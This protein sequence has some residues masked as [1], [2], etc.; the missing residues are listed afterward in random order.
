MSVALRFL[1]DVRLKQFLYVTTDCLDVMC[2]DASASDGNWS[3]VARVDAVLHQVCLSKTGEQV[4]ELLSDEFPEFFCSRLGDLIQASDSVQPGGRLLGK[5]ST[6]LLWPPLNVRLKVVR[7][8]VGPDL[9][10]QAAVQ[11]V[12]H[13]SLETVLEVGLLNDG[14]ELAGHLFQ[15]PNAGRV[16]LILDADAPHSFIHQTA[17]G[18]FRGVLLLQGDAVGVTWVDCRS[19]G[20]KL[21]CIIDVQFQ[22]RLFRSFP[23][24]EE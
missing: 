12:E 15:F 4:A 23:E 19:E 6:F 14:V 3:V 17:D 5:R 18:S 1:D 11:H 20:S 9:S 8:L 22:D 2:R 7:F 13:I 10:G 21:R 24:P 16:K